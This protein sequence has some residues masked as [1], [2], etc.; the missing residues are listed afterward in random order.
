MPGG[1]GHAW[2]ANK[3]GLKKFPHGRKVLKDDKKV[4]DFLMI[5]RLRGKITGPAGPVPLIGRHSG[6]PGG[7]GHA[8]VANKF[9]LKKF[10][11]GRKVQG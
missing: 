4:V 7:K 11:H 1:K 2:V 3:F 9:G 5:Q 8:W 6:M 10:P